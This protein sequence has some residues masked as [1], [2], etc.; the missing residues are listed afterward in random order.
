M[1]LWHLGIL[2]R[3]RCQHHD[4]TSHRFNEK[5]CSWPVH[6]CD[7]RNI[8]KQNGLWSTSKYRIVRQD[9]QSCMQLDRVLLVSL[10]HSGSANHIDIIPNSNSFFI[11]G[12]LFTDNYNL[13]MG[14]NL[15][16][17]SLSFQHFNLLVRWKQNFFGMLCQISA[18]YDNSI[19]ASIFDLQ[20]FVL[21]CALFHH[22][23]FCS[24]DSVL[25]CMRV[26][27]SQIILRFDCV[28]F[29]SFLWTHSEH[30]LCFCD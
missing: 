23:S 22:N 27:L 10:F 9:L 4:R 11:F 30:G 14:T 12:V 3:P 2:I 6:Y 16:F 28:V 1:S 24:N 5:A 29:N 15:Y 21:Y 25:V 20:I 18:F 13:D 7:E 8:L 26:L 19:K 17:S